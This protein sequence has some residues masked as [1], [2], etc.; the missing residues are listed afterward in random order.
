MWIMAQEK[1]KLLLADAGARLVGNVALVDRAG[2][3]ISVIT[4][5]QWMFSGVKTRHWGILPL[6][7]VSDD[8]VS[9]A[10][11]YGLM[12]L[13]ALSGGG[14]SELQPQIVRAGGV[15]IKPFLVLT[16][17]TG[18]KLFAKWAKF[19]TAHPQSRQALLKAFNI[20]LFVAIWFISPIVYILHLISLPL[21]IRQIRKDKIYFQGAALADGEHV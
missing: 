14:F 7:G 4:I 17:R 18:N 13:S 20:Y 8:D 11:Q 10:S 3:L 6:P 1:V 19:I 9:Q 16:D 12:M 5:V 2:N 15:K 21:K